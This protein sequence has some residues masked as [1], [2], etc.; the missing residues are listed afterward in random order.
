MNHKNSYSNHFLEKIDSLKSQNKIFVILGQI[1][2]INLKT[3]KKYMSDEM[4]FYERSNFEIF[5][6][7]WLFRVTAELNTNKSYHLLS[8]PQFVYLRKKFTS[9]VFFDRIVILRDNLRK[10]YV[11]NENEY[12]ES[13]Q[14]ESIELRPNKLPDFQVNQIKIEDKYFYTVNTSY[15]EGYD[16]KEI[17][18]KEKELEKGQN[19]ESSY[20]LD[21]YEDNSL[22]MYFEECF[23]IGKFKDAI[24][25]IN[26]KNPV[27]NQ[28][29]EVLKKA[30][31]YIEGF[32]VSIFSHTIESKI[33]EEKPNIELKKKLQKYWGVDAVFRTFPVYIDPIK[34]NE[35]TEIS[36]SAI[37]EKL[38]DEYK[39]A[40][41]NQPFKDVFL[42]APTG[43]G[44][45]LLFQLSAFH[46]SNEGDVTIVISP[47]IA[48]MKD[49]VNAIINN[50]DYQKV[51]FV[52]S[53]LNYNDRI[54][55]LEKCKNGE[56]DIL[57][58]S[59]ELFLSYQIPHFIGDRNL[60]LLVIDEAHL[61]TTW[62]RD[63]RVDYWFLGNHISKLRKYYDLKFPMIA[64]TATA[65]YGGENDMVFDCIDSLAMKNP[66][67]YIGK[68]IRDD[69]EFV[70]NRYEDFGQGYQKKKV[71][72]SSK[73]IKGVNNLNIKTLL[74]VPYTKH[75]NEILNELDR[76][77]RNITGGYHGK[78][79][80]E[81]K[82]VSYK[83]FKTG[84]FRTLISTKAFGMGVD[85][86]D[87]QVIY[88]H[89]PSGL[90][91]DYIQEIGRAAREKGLLGYAA[92]NYSTKDQSFAKVLHGISAIR[93]YQIKA[94]LK[95][96]FQ[97]H[98]KEMSRNILLSVE[99]FSHVFD[100]DH[101]LDQKVMT[102]LMMIE[103]DYLKKYQF[104]VLV[105]RPRKL[106]VKVF[107][108]IQKIHLSTLNQLFPNTLK[109]IGIENKDCIIE[110]DLHE[111]WKNHYKGESF[112]MFKQRFY[113]K[114]LL[115][116]STTEIEPL[117]QFSLNL[118]HEYFN[119]SQKL[120]NIFSNI[121]KVFEK[122]DK[123][124]FT[125]EVLEKKL[126]E[127]FENKIIG[128]ALSKFLLSSYSGLQ[129]SFS[130]IEGD[131]FL[132]KRL[133]SKSKYEYRIFS[134]KYLHRFKSLEKLL[135]RMYKD[136]KSLEVVKYV[137]DIQLNQLQYLRLGQLIEVLELGTF[138]IKGGEQ[139]MIFVR[140]NDPNRIYQDFANNKYSNS[141]LKSTLDRYKISYKIFDRFFNKKFT[142]TQRWSFVEDLFLGES[143]EF[144]VENYEGEE[145]SELDIVKYLSN[146]DLK[147]VIIEKKERNDTNI[148]IFRPDSKKTYLEKSF[149]TLMTENEKVE[150]MR[151]WD[152][153]KYNPILLNQTV[154]K[155]SLKLERQMFNHLNNVLRTDHHKYYKSVTGIHYKVNFPGYDKP[156]KAKIPYD[157]EPVKFYKW[158]LKDE[159]QVVLKK[160]DKVK[161][162]DKVY[163]MSPQSLK[164]KHLKLIRERNI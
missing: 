141:I 49:Q 47:L 96:I 105:A 125:S 3:K 7:N 100:S 164:M 130:S 46:I 84:E 72:Q 32:G 146:K 83:K 152:W 20:Y 126:T 153:I 133:T 9:L 28:T 64:V 123:G 13:E 111:L 77:D 66:H 147:E 145:P 58:M 161:L 158:W 139:L 65:I 140:L 154:K 22:D 119:T 116:D 79:T 53:E 95:K 89:A 94:V 51:S 138:E 1:E 162:F 19:K 85:I 29:Y 56:I 42:T 6:E 44:K 63:F 45:S 127:T 21:I 74:Y 40:K 38:I 92:V 128:R 43:V 33:L 118:K 54:E 76:D 124:Y 110:L 59:P 109:E 67:I 2:L 151:I 70:V 5:D 30:N 81:N 80:P 108:K 117:I 31:Y 78:M 106:F 102:A 156:I 142:N 104:N 115:Q 101:D 90:L 60:G 12:L 135:H 27:S 120:E 121:I 160:I 103:K 88:H 39:K 16:I 129:K 97:V 71:T 86:K 37:V 144:I 155:E 73:F 159:N 48:L 134:K 157:L 107:A 24:V 11:I 34:G 26:P 41:N 132:H 52:N 69:I 61:I 113:N 10:L 25:N 114:R 36:Q 149:L 57:Y 122:I 137:K 99:D 14:N 55:V 8:Y 18:S 136:K 35:I 62:G 91:P 112:P 4:S 143:L 87:I 50:R 17:F 98:K 68:I 75:V 150:T 15:T 148:H 82:D 23:L 131:A 163:S 93:Q